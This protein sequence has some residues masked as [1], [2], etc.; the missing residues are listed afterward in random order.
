M[1]KASEQEQICSFFYRKAGSPSSWV[2][3][4]SVV[5][6]PTPEPPN[7]WATGALLSSTKRRNPFLRDRPT[8]PNSIINFWPNY[9]KTIGYMTSQR[10]EA[11]SQQASN[12]PAPACAS[13]ADTSSLT[14]LQRSHIHCFGPVN[15]EKAKLS[16]W[17][18]AKCACFDS[19]R[20][21]YSLYLET[22]E[23]EKNASGPRGEK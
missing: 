10:L 11:E 8:A 16:M 14:T 5:S 1:R 3:C 6:S 9:L 17:T 19:E 7:C 12:P 2:F 13:A 23:A 18:C 15:G 4:I 22:P 21:V 20:S